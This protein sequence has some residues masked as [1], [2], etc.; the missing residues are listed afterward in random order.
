MAVPS[1][2]QVCGRLIAGL[3]CSNSAGNMNV[4]HVCLLCV[5]RVADSVTSLSFVQRSAVEPRVIYKHQDLRPIR[6]VA[7]QEKINVCVCLIHST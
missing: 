3:A 2:A 4:R 1:K 7:P 5:V 6:A